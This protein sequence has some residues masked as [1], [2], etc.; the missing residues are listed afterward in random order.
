M[1]KHGH[2]KR[3]INSCPS[4]TVLPLCSLSASARHRK[5]KRE[6]EKIISR[7]ETRQIRSTQYEQ[8]ESL[9]NFFDNR[10]F[11]YSER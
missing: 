5:R 10:G 6:R 4:F 2:A 1:M 11:I 8:Q 3:V 7:N 9:I